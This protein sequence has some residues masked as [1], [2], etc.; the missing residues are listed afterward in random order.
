MDSGRTAEKQVRRSVA[1]PLTSWPLAGGLRV[2][3]CLARAGRFKARRPWSLPFSCGRSEESL[4]RLRNG[5]T[6][7]L[8]VALQPPTPAPNSLHNPR[9][10]AVLSPSGPLPQSTLLPLRPKLGHLDIIDAASL[11]VVPANSLTIPTAVD[12]E[13][14]FARLDSRLFTLNRL[15]RYVILTAAADSIL[16]RA[17]PTSAGPSLALETSA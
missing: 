9:L 13:W 12:S 3:E 17:Y 8:L 11:A 1:S 2:C 15:T 16:R 4:V 10:V 14:I 5:I 7:S 6:S